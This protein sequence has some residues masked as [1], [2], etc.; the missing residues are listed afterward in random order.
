MAFLLML[1]AGSGADCP[2]SGNGNQNSNGNG[3]QNSNG[4]NNGNG[5][6]TLTLHGQLGSET[7]MLARVWV[8]NRVVARSEMDD[9]NALRSAGIL[10]TEVSSDGEPGDVVRQIF[11]E[12]GDIVTIIA[13]E[14]EG[15]LNPTQFSETPAPL[16]NVVE[17]LNFTGAPVSTPEPGVASFTVGD[18]DIE[19]TANFQRMPQIVLFGWGVFSSHFEL[20]IPPVLGI[21]QVDNPYNGDV[22]KS[23][24]I[25]A[26]DKSVHTTM[27]FKSGSTVLLTITP[28]GEFIRWE[29][30]CSGSTPE[31]MLTFGGLTGQSDFV[32]TAVCG[33]RECTMGSSTLYSGYGD[34]NNPGA[35]CMIVRP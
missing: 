15:I 29:G 28:T 26:P 20:D 10:D 2:P 34:P 35:G 23:S 3:N 25:F 9:P 21:T 6:V 16:D 24:T 33:Y 30:E 11:A 1:L 27:Q 17:F 4:N 12:P 19:V 14:S 31:C 22:D 5:M 32:T 8:G 7:A 18:D 13:I